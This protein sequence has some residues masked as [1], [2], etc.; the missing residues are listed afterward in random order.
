MGLLNSNQATV[1]DHSVSG[2]VKVLKV[3]RCDLSDQVHSDS[4]WLGGAMMT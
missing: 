1:N 3:E 4:R 2:Y